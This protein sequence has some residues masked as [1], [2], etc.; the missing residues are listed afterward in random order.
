[1]G[2]RPAL[3]RAREARRLTRPEFA[4]LMGA[5]RHYVY[6]VEMGLRNPSFDFMRRWIKALGPDATLDLF[7][8][9]SRAA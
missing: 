6:A 9:K 3:I 5:S 8:N 4:K 1:M 2:T 7:D